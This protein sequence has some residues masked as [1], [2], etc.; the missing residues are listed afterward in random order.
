MTEP[1]AVPPLTPPPPPPDRPRFSP[2]LRLA[3]RWAT[4]LLLVFALGLGATWLAQVR[5]LQL[6]VEA[7]EQERATLEAH[8]A[9]LQL[10]VQALEAVRAENASLKVDQARL[11]QQ[12]LVL[13]AMSATAQAQLALAGGSGVDAP[14]PLLSRVEGYLAALQEVLAG[15]MQQEVR[16]LRDRLALAAGELTSDPFAAQRDLEILANGLRMLEEQLSGA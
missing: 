3:L 14:G 9:D 1:A 5:P 7:L 8:A 6:R 16:D 4:G 12:R 13:Q 15:S 11:E 2:W 10:Q